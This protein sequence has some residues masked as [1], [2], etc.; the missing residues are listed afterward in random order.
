MSSGAA[1]AALG[2]IT[3]NMAVS[4]GGSI[5]GVGFVTVISSTFAYL[6]V[7]AAPATTIVYASGYLSPKDLLQAGY[8]MALISVIILMGF[9]TFYWPLVGLPR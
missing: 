1:V 2:P 7:I 3:L 6:T 4:T 5:V 9:V 8:K